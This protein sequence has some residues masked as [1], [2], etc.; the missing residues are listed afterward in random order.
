[1]ILSALGCIAARRGDTEAARSHFAQAAS[2]SPD[3]CFP[4]RLHEQ[5]AL[6]V[7]RTLVP[8]DPRA[9][10][11]LGNLL[12]DKRR[13]EAA[14]AAWEDAARLDPSFSIPWRNLGFAYYNIRRSP[15]KAG[16]AFAQAFAA[17]PNDPRL[18]Y[19]FDQFRKHTGVSPAERLAVLEQAGDLLGRR[20]DLFIERVTLCNHLGR[21]EKALEL[22]LSHRFHPWE[23]G[24]TLVAVQYDTARL[25]LGRRALAEGDAAAALAHLESARHYP[26]NLGVAR[27]RAMADAHLRYETGLAREASGDPAGA[28]A[29]WRAIVD[30][31]P[32]FPFERYYRALALRRL[33]DESAATR[34]LDGLLAYA[35]SKAQEPVSTGY[36]ENY[37]M[38]LSLFDEDQDRLNRI[39][40]GY[41]AA[42]AKLGL[43]RIEEARADFA[44][45]L[46]LDPNHLLAQLELDR[47]PVG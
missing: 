15:H 5:L 21:P 17:D 41:L 40:C 4:S 23:G 30:S 42:L 32:A 20:D 2:A 46:A 11:Y 45:V 34:E 18:L 19:E 6:E 9:P 3:F 28:A 26:E 36:F 8:D 1:M 35:E 43:G 31:P 29:D 22:M 38:A 37:A 16:Q 13:Y 33:G 27:F 47:L 10:Y 25:L 39:E 12:Y 14:I 24:E 44:G 7:A